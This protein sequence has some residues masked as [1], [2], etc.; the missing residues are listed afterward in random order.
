MLELPKHPLLKYILFGILYFSE[1]LIYALASV[2]IVLYFTEEG[3]S[4]VTT[5]LVGGIV[6]SPW[7]LKFV[8]GP[9]VDYFGKYGRKMFIIIGGI[10]G[11]I[12]IFMTAF[13]DPNSSLILFTLFLFIGHAGIILIDV[14]ADA[15]AI[16]TTKIHE[17][18]KVNAAMSTGIFS[19]I[20]AGGIFLAFIATYF[21]FEMVFITS[22]ILIFLSIILPMCI[23]EDII[24]I[25]RKTI[26]PLLLSEF[27]KRNTQLVV[28]LTFVIGLNFGMLRFIIPEYMTNVLFLDNIQIGFLT[29]VYYILII[30]GAI[31]GGIFVDK[32]GRKKILYLTLTGLLISLALLVFADTWEKLGIIYGI[33]GLMTGASSYS[34]IAALLM[35]I[36]NPKVGAAQYSIMASISNLGMIGIAT[37]S[38]SLIIIL[39]YNRFFLYAALT[40]GITLLLLY[41]IKETHKHHNLK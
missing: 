32:W 25:K 3:I 24:K 5:A 28:L 34:A 33:I 10:I 1:G 26:K 36:T 9:T 29:S 12:A 39:G 21:G 11:G 22:A 15:W 17:K 4:I 19:G 23:K 37:V 31:L 16:Q 13:I 18:G 30:I 38:G 41:F 40:V 8:L 2:I 7:V 35:D 14:S 6:S 27:K 20:A